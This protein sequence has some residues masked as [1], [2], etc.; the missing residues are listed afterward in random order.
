MFYRE[1]SGNMTKNIT[2]WNPGESGNPKGRPPKP[3]ALTELLRLRGEDVSVIGSEA[4]SQK[5]ILAKA[6]W[7]FVTT[8]EVWLAGRRLTAENI[9]EWASVV[10]WLYGYMEPPNNEPEQEPEMVV[11]I[12][13][14]DEED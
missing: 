8:G 5:D 9:T 1:R 3:R 2:S 12:V 6:V 4:V 13:R 10:K 11:R 7:Q 14:V